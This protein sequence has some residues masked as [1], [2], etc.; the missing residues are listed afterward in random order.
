[1]CLEINLKHEKRRVLNGTLYGDIDVVHLQFKDVG[2][3][4]FKTEIHSFDI[5]TGK[6]GNYNILK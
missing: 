5:N 1:M 2:Q 4:F 6:R 3:T